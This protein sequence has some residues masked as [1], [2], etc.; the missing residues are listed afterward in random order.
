MFVQPTNTLKFR[1]SIRMP[2]SYQSLHIP[3][4]TP[5]FLIRHRKMISFLVETHD[6][7]WNLS[8]KRN[9]GRNCKRH[10]SNNLPKSLSRRSLAIRKDYTPG[11]F[12]QVG[13]PICLSIFEWISYDLSR[14]LAYDLPSRLSRDISRDLFKS[15]TRMCDGLIS[16]V[17]QFRVLLDLSK[18]REMY[19]MPVPT[20]CWLAGRPITM[21]SSYPSSLP[22]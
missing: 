13:N 18:S 5:L 16:S 10:E 17:I 3:N 6:S 20:C 15:F 9:K 22:R 2:F 21:A 1:I 4:D 14:D 19:S 7:P 11:S 8:Q 12:R